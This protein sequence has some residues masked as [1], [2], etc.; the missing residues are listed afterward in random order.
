[1]SLLAM[2]KPNGKSGFG[3]GSTAEDVTANVDLTGKFVVLTGCNSGLGKECLRVLGLRGAYVAALAR[4]EAK[5]QAALDDTGTQGIAVACELSDPVSVRA[6]V[7][8]VLQEGRPVDRVLCNA[9]IMA[10]PQLETAHGYELQFFTNHIGHFL[11]VTG[12]LDHLADDARVVL[13]S[14]GAHQMAP[15]GGIEFDNLD[16]SQGYTPIR[17]YGQSK[18][19]NILFAMG[20]AKRFEGSERVANAVHPG[21]I[22]TNLGRSMSSVANVVMR[23]ASPLVMKNAAQGAATQMFAAFHDDGARWS[24][25]YLSDCNLDKARDDATEELAERLWQTSEAIASDV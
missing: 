13:T 8:R 5:A 16:G 2:L 17:A 25:E 11:L 19:A 15:K 23:I 4:T 20:L 14:S 7:A 6:A 24:G 10:L 1:M 22:A 18:M 12:L 21:V 3:Y 9:G